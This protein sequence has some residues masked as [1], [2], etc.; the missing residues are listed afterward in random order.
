[1]E[2]ARKVAAQQK[3]TKEEEEEDKEEPTLTEEPKREKEEE[4]NLTEEQKREKEEVERK[5]EKVKE[6]QLMIRAKKAGDDKMWAVIQGVWVEMLCFSAGRCRGY[7]HAKSL[8]KGGEYLSYVWLLSYMGMETMPEKMQRP[9]LPVEG[10]VGGLVKPI[11]EEI[12]VK[13]AK[14]TKKGGVP[15][16]KGQGGDTKDMK[17]AP[18][19]T[20]EQGGDTTKLAQ[21]A[22]PLVATTA[23]TSATDMK[24]A[25]QGDLQ[26][27]TG[28]ENEPEGDRKQAQ[29]TAATK[30]AT[31]A[32]AVAPIIGDDNV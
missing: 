17:P 18:T 28:M 11:S 26:E 7:L 5:T 4:P 23:S 24:K 21:A 6:K 25:E 20:T 15:A 8:G 10:D 12:A 32:A 30:A 2:L 1:M 3:E 29:A 31:L 22:A 9:G 14:E 13:P 19:G 27:L 16:K